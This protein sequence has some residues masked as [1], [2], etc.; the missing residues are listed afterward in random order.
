MD[1]AAVDRWLDAGRPGEG[2]TKALTHA[3]ACA[4]CARSLA[5]A[6]E[7]DR[8]LAQ[9]FAT[10]PDGFTDHVMA[11]LPARPPVRRA[12][13]PLD[14]DPVL[15]WW[16]R[17]VQEPLTVASFLLGIVFLGFGGHLWGSGRVFFS[18]AAARIETAVAP[19]AGAVANSVPGPGWIPDAGLLLVSATL[20]W[21]LYRFT[22]TREG[23]R[24]DAP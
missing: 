12:A 21:F 6:R 15:P 3:G 4:R 22:V 23:L 16:V 13:S 1:C 17:I 2:R 9:R 11:R 19:V 10:A 18:D 24:T 7:L 8:V 20:A 14:L 5:A